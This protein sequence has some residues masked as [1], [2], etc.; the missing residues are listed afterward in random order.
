MRTN[1]EDFLDSGPSFQRAWILL[2]QLAVPPSIE[3]FEHGYI[4][5]NRDHPH[6]SPPSYAL[7]LKQN[8]TRGPTPYSSHGSYASGASVAR[9]CDG[10]PDMRRAPVDAERMRRE[11][12]AEWDFEAWLRVQAEALLASLGTS[13]EKHAAFNRFVNDND[14]ED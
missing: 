2:Q 3:V 8:Y 4:D 6:L 7:H 9:G 10:L 11:A 1:H 5:A 14:P 12:I 13:L